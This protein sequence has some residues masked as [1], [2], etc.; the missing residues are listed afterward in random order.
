[1]LLAAAMAVYLLVLTLLTQSQ[2]EADLGSF[3][4]ALRNRSR[5]W[6]LTQ[7]IQEGLQS[8]AVGV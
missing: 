4:V 1:L 6:G 2:D 5:A 7:Q 8:G 3:G